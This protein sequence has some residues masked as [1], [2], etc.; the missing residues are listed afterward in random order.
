[1]GS[2]ARKARSSPGATTVSPSGLSRSEATLAT[3]FVAATPQ[4]TV[5]PVSRRT[6]ARSQR[7]ITAGSVPASTRCV[8]S[9]NAS[10]S[11]SGSTSGVTRRKMAIT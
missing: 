11:E 1:M 4:D 7:A 3:D 8:T 6:A 2:G 5:R 10:S 9:R